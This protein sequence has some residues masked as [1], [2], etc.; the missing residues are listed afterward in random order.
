MKKLLLLLLISNTIFAQ[1]N[2]QNSSNG[3]VTISPNGIL[4]NFPTTQQNDTTNIAIGENALRS[5]I[6]GS[7]RHIAIGKN[8]LSK[9]TFVPN[10]LNDPDLSSQLAIGYGALAKYNPSIDGSNI[11]IGV[12][13]MGNV[14][15]QDAGNNIAIG[16]LNMQNTDARGVISIG[17]AALLASINSGSS[18]SESIYI[19]HQIG[20]LGANGNRNTVLGNSAF[21]KSNG[22]QNTLV[23]FE[24]GYSLGSSSYTEGNIM[25]GFRAG[26]NELGSNKLYIENSDSTNTLIG[27]DFYF[28][29]VGINR[30]ASQIS[31]TNRTFQVEGSAIISDILQLPL[32]ASAGKV[33]TSDVD[34]N[35]SWQTPSGLWQVAGAGNSIQNTNTGGFWS[36]YPAPLPVGANNTTYPP[37]SPTEGNG[38]RMAWIPARSAFQGGTFNMADGSVRFISENIGLFSFC[39]GLNSESRSRGG[40]AIGEGAIAD[41]TSNTIAIGESL[42]SRGENSFLGGFGSQIQDGT[43]NTILF[44]ESSNATAGQHNYGYGW[45]LNMSGFGSS[46]VGSYNSTLGGSNTSWVS[47]DPLFV[48]GNGQSDAIRSNAFVIQK[49][50]VTNIGIIPGASTTYK[51]RVGGSISASID[52]QASNLRATNLAGSGE[53]N[54]C[55]DASGNLITCASS[56]YNVSALGF[57]AKLSSGTASTVFERDVEKSLVYFT[58][59]T[60]NTGNYA[61]AP[62]ELPNGSEIMKLFLNY[63]QVGGSN[64]MTLSLLRIPKTLNGTATALMALDT[65]AGTNILEVTDVPK[66]TIIIENDKYYYYLKFEATSTWKGTS[67]ALRGVI[68]QYKN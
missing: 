58:S 6:L 62:V 67:M 48:I 21:R 43:S 66:S 45:G 34:G 54:V 63:V 35:A 46:Y 17:N 26:K 68:I 59:T 42:A 33:L 1:I 9:F 2:I 53:R 22:S 11:A 50:G 60:S 25:L 19:G 31:S 5:N 10:V 3:G 4:A 36:T 52:M 64:I 61:F 57:H 39:Y 18:T 12:K 28:N 23:G 65:V 32:G 49:N 8:A 14:T 38:T 13:A 55:T 20:I 40:V 30:S 15:F 51:L 56:F 41:G 16:H 47:T 27:G 44:G 24:T 7:Q 37:T 29:R